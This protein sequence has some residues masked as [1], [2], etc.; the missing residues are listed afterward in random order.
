MITYLLQ[1]PLYQVATRAAYGTA[2]AKLAKNNNRVIAVDG[3]TKNSTFSEK[4][5]ASYFRH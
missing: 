2:L 3:D 1:S 4:I 5:K